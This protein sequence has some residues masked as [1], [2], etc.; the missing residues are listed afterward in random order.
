MPLMGS[1]YVGQSG[2]QTSQ[3]ALNT[4]AHNMSNADTVGYVRQ[5]VLQG[6][7]IYNTIKVDFKAIANQQVGLGVNYSKTRQVRDYFLDKTYRQE[8]G[9]Q[10]FYT[11]SR[12]AL[13][14]I[15][16]LL[17]EMNGE[18]F[19]DSLDNL[20]TSVQELTKDPSSAVTQGLLI[21]R[22][23]EFLDRADA[24]YEG[25]KDY[26]NNLNSTI[27]E[28]VDTINDHAKAIKELNDRIRHIEVAGFEEAN[29]LRDA[30]NQ[31]IDE[32]AGMANISYSEDTEGNICIQLEGE[33][34]VKRDVVYEIGLDQDP[35]TGFYTPFWIHN[36]PFTINV[37]GERE[38]N[39]EGALVY[40]ME[41]VIS[42]DLNTDVGSL[43]STLIA[44]G[45]HVA[46][47]KDLEE[48]NYTNSV[49]QSVVMNVQAEFD[50][51]IHNIATTMNKVLADAAEA[52]YAAGDT[53]YLRDKN[54][55]PIQIFQK[56]ATEG[57]DE[58]GRFI[59]EGYDED[60]NY[61]PEEDTIYNW[62]TIDNLKINQELLQQPTLLGFVLHD[63]SV[64]FDTMEK[65]KEAFM[66]E[67]STL[68]PFVKKQSSFMDYYSDLVAQIAN[69]GHVYE[70]ILTNQQETVDST[71]SA[72]EQIIGVSA[73]EELTNMVK[74]QN[75][76]NASS[77]YINVID[78]MIEHIINTLGM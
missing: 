27:K 34:L 23:A 3:N 22:C 68:N 72:R 21:E 12:D 49:T 29:D 20:W 35:E 59:T 48:K 69:S 16:F 8:L 5:Q 4:T 31:L 77:R 51:L 9:R 47:F 46:N 74:F 28:K 7:R 63:D 41:Q 60:G 24:V 43:K 32:L 39:I 76:Y 52:A 54:G 36:A 6:T 73:D 44:R 53:T 2:L 1:L 40:D 26:Q 19:Q 33:D 15:E 62:Y 58:N 70:S 55:N 64:D 57:Y 67:S 42:S 45:D 38:Y 56:I 18:T 71:F 61:I 25:L 30:R 17:D 66:A 78:E 13:E 50:Q 14:E 65:M 10:E 37:D 75:A 11:V